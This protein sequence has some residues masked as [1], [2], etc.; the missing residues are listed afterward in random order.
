M[1]IQQDSTGLDIQKALNAV[2]LPPRA[3]REL[4]RISQQR[5]VEIQRIVDTVTSDEALTARVI[6]VVNSA[7]F[8]TTRQITSVQQAT[9]LLGR[10][11]VVQIAVGVAALH[12]ETGLPADLPLSRQAFWRHSMGTAFVARRLSQDRPGLNPEQAFTAGLL[13]DIG[14]LVLMG[15]LG[16]EYTHVL[17]QAEAEGRPLDAMER[18][19]FGVDHGDVVRALCTKWTLSDT[20]R[21]GVAM[22][23]ADDEATP[24]NRV[25]QAAN[26]IAKAA[27]VGNSGNPYAAL[28]RLHADVV[29]PLMHD[30]SFIRVLPGEVQRIEQAFRLGVGEQPSPPAEAPP[31]ASRRTVL[32]EVDDDALGALAAVALAALGLTPHRPTGPA[33]DGALPDAGD[34]DAPVARLTAG[35][36]APPDA[37]EPWLDVA[38]WREKQHGAD[39]DT[40]HLGAFRAW[41]A[42]E[43]GATPSSP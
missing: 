18:A 16:P 17:E 27:G 42:R 13:H 36:A 30:L 41:L 3:V 37:D 28:N 40:I 34:A 19:I 9:V 25:V 35:R 2:P 26:A 10:E 23:G 11:A 29:A 31:A 38:A 20:L 22:H 1:S 21:E 12:V 7:L 39:P 8:G 32:V 6:R 33:S 15:Y 4:L 24:L 43:L 14:K 5:D